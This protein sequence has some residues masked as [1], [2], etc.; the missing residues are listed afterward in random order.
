[1]DGTAASSVYVLN[2][3]L[4]GVY[5]LYLAGILGLL[6]VLHHIA[7]DN[8]S[9]IKPMRQVN[10]NFVLQISTIMILG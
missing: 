5:V 2:P 6:H 10:A 8:L 4:G 1:M 9:V 3:M 7:L